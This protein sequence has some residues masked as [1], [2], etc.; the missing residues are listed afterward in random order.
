MPEWWPL[1]FALGYWPWP[2]TQVSR[3]AAVHVQSRVLAEWLRWRGVAYLGHITD[4]SA[5]GADSGT[6]FVPSSVVPTP[7]HDSG[8]FETR[9]E[10]CQMAGRGSQKGKSRACLKQRL[11]IVTVSSWILLFLLSDCVCGQVCVAAETC[12]IQKVCACSHDAKTRRERRKGI[13]SFFG[14]CR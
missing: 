3:A 7:H 8:R 2:R 1:L 11:H 6:R 5:P 12:L 14:C 4:R 13:D 10:P 9:S